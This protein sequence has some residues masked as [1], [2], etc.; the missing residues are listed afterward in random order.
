MYNGYGADLFR[1][2]FS[3]MGL[4]LHVLSNMAGELSFENLFWMSKLDAMSEEICK[5]QLN[6]YFVE[7]IL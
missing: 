7:Y 1:M 3:K 2:T 5:S 4:P 6:S